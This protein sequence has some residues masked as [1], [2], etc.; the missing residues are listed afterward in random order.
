MRQLPFLIVAIAVAAGCS[1]EA[2]IPTAPEHS[3]LIPKHVTSAQRQAFRQLEQSTEQPWTWL[4]HDDLGT[5]MHLASPRTGLPLLRQGAD[6]GTVT[7]ALLDRHRELFRLRDAARELRLVNTQTDALG[8]THARLQ[9]TVRGVPVRGGELA[10]HYD[11]LGHVASIDA[12]Y[13]PDLEDLDLTPALS[14]DEAVRAAKAEALS[15]TPAEEASLTIGTPKLI[16]HARPATSGGAR[17]GYELSVRALDAE[18]PAIWVVIVDA[19]NGEVLERYN[20]LQTVDASGTGVLGDLKKF[21][22]SNGNSSLV[23]TDASTGVQIRTFTANQQQLNLSESFRGS[24]VTSDDPNSWDTGVPGAGA[25]VD[26]HAHAAIVY[27]YYKTTHARN[28]IDGSGGALYSTVHYGRSYDNAFWDGTGMAYGDGG[29]AFRPLSVSLDVVGHEFTHGVIERTA[30]LIYQNQSGALN[31]A[32]ADIFGAFIE[33]KAKPDPARNWMLGEA[34]S[35]SNSPLRDMKTPSVGNQPAHM[36]Q[37]VNTQQDNGGV[38]INSGIINNAAYLM[39]A[40]GTNPVSNVEVKFGIGWE[41]SEK[42]W[43]RALTTYFMQSTSFAQAAQ[44][45]LQAAKDIG[46]TQNETNIV[47]CAFKATGLVS[48]MC[49]AIVNP[50]TPP[51]PPPTTPPTPDNNGGGSTTPG[52]DTNAEDSSGDTAGD[53]ADEEADE[54]SP[55]TKRRRRIVTQGGS[56]G[57]MSVPGET[58]ATPAF[59]V[60][61]AAAIGAAKRRFRR[62]AS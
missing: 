14:A 25:A 9:Q 18:N 55:S 60:A 61:L 34:M 12:H 36:R 22:V 15:L 4:Q 57:C 40:G 56:A 44:G 48:G 16:V 62:K 35:R 5:P 42:L 23:M 43:Y 32:V 58:S 47:E 8:M 39:T 10:V 31:E 2:S 17:L 24:S 27:D 51:A 50:Q 7:L 26:A 46:L 1:S 38:H 11:A 19:K 41:K 28:A 6:P 33:H 13:V 53:N 20:N 45:V 54:D 52:S 21:K 37:F 59:V 30:G 3:S 29:Q 49:A